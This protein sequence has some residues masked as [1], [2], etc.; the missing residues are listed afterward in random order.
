METLRKEFGWSM[1]APA[2]A[3]ALTAWAALF[4]A[5]SFEVFGQYGRDTL[6]DPGAFF[7][8]QVELLAD[9]VGLPN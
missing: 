7:A 1:P 4:G 2:A 8:H 6:T 5:V 9:L 3:R